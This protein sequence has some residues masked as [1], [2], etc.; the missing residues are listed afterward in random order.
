MSGKVCPHQNHICKEC[1]RQF[2]LFPDKKLVPVE[3]KSLVD[4]LLLERISLAGIARVTGVSES[5]LQ[6]Y[7]NKKMAEIPK[8]IEF[9]SGFT[10]KDILLVECD[11]LWSFVQNKENKQWVWLAMNQQ[12]RQ[13]IGVHIG[14]RGEDG[15]RCLW[16][17]L[18]QV[19]KDE[20][21]YYIDG[22]PAYGALIP[23]GR[24]IVVGKE[25]GKTSLIERFNN[26]IRQRLSRFVRKTLSFS[27]KIENHIGSVWLFIHDYNAS[28]RI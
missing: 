11:E 25:S 20:A 4:K 9:K 14:S 21:F 6:R 26:T 19:C 28:L 18:P 23:T 8:T 16:N 5:W 1:G 7:V 3:T 22:H 27:K 13:I 2:V 10:Q 24:H 15:A 12:T 17:S